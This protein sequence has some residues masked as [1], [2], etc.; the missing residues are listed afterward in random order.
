M[1]GGGKGERREGGKEVGVII[2][3]Q[4]KGSLGVGTAQYLGCG[5]GYMDLHRG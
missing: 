4:H 1:E 5:G 2:K 3:G